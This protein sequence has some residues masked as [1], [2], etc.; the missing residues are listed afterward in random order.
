MARGLSLDDVTTF[1]VSGN[2]HP[3]Q[4]HKQ[5]HRSNIV[6]EYN[7]TM[8]ETVAIDVET[9]LKQVDDGAGKKSK[10]EKKLKKSKTDEEPTKNDN[11][12]DELDIVQ[13]H[14][15]SNVFRNKVTLKSCEKSWDKKRAA[16]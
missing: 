2:G 7:L 5:T 14:I 16:S 3:K 6:A 4:K 8:S 12:S 13:S 15:G 9:E 11:A 10:K 1:G